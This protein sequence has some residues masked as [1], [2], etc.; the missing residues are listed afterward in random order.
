MTLPKIDSGALHREKLAALHV[1]HGPD[2]MQSPTSTTCER[3]TQ[4]LSRSRKLIGWMTEHLG[5]LTPEAIEAPI[6][7]D[8]YLTPKMENYFREHGEAAGLD[9]L[10]QLMDWSLAQARGASN[11]TA[12]PDAAG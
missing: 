10:R 4:A 11:C 12:S 5:Q 6:Q 2:G 8:A 1:E 3:A 7:L 9:L